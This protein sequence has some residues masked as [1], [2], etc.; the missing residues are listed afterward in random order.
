MNN[1]LC[2]KTYHVNDLRRKSGSSHFYYFIPP[3][4]ST[5]TIYDYYGG[6]VVEK[7]KGGWISQHRLKSILLELSSE[8]GLSWSVQDYYD[9]WILN[10]TTPSDRPKCLNCG[11][12]VQF[13]KLADGYNSFCSK[14]CGSEYNNKL[15]LIG[16]GMIWDESNLKYKESREA[17]IAARKYN[18]EHGIIG[19]GLMWSDEVTYKNYHDTMHKYFDNGGTFKLMHDDPNSYF[20]TQEYHELRSKL[21]TDMNYRLWDDPLSTFNSEDFRRKLSEIHTQVMYDRWSD[22]N[23]TFNSKEYRAK[24]S[25]IARIRL[26]YIWA[27]PEEYPDFHEA[28]RILA[29]NGGAYGIMWSHPELYNL[30]NSSFKKGR[31]LTNKSGLVR[32]MSGYELRLIEL[33]EADPQVAYFRSQPLS[34]K[35]HHFDG[36]LHR[37]IPDFLVTYTDGS[38]LL[39]EVKPTCFLDTEINKL[40]FSVGEAY[41]KSQGWDW[42]VLTENELWS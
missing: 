18:F 31:I 6:L 14:G 16:L 10:I 34:I 41:A 27:H 11:R 4:W 24:L 40:K 2:L 7:D 39:I 28:Q 38:K 30:G 25:N 17:L 29:E 9:R 35:Y 23:D 13:R 33:L 36:S 37:Y 1:F 32:Y 3:E 20:H 15:G 8:L 5:K 19:F 12:E 21:T 26:K 22:P 42:A